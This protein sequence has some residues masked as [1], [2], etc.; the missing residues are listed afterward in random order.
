LPGVV[1]VVLGDHA[2][3]GYVRGR[4]EGIASADSTESQS[5]TWAARPSHSRRIMT[6]R[7]LPG[8]VIRVDLGGLNHTIPQLLPPRRLGD[9]A[10]WG[11]CASLRD[12]VTR[13]GRWAR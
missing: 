7:T 10:P 13:T 12:Y 11:V 8:H 3:G 9:I 4:R 5:M 1:V 2:P 6:L